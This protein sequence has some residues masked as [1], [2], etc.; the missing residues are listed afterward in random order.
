MK[1][2]NDIT[3]SDMSRI[4]VKELSAGVVTGDIDVAIGVT[5][6]TA[7]ERW[8]ISESSGETFSKK[9]EK[10]GDGDWRAEEE[11][12]LL[13]VVARKHGEVGGGEFEVRKG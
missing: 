4:G 6:E 3:N 2:R 12:A 13:D 9:E 10:I 1:R 5:D 11:V 7:G 8:E